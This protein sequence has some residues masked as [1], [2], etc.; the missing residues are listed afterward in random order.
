MV[1]WFRKIS[2]FFMERKSLSDFSNVSCEWL[3]ILINNVNVSSSVHAKVAN[4]AFWDK[5]R[6]LT[7]NCSQSSAWNKPFVKH[8]YKCFHLFILTNWAVNLSEGWNI[9]SQEPTY[10]LGK[11]WKHSQSW[12]LVIFFKAARYKTKNWTYFSFT[13]ILNSKWV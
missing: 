10:C 12:N 5:L 7:H 8:K 9:K 6:L 1:S 11:P 2:V 3:E 4:W 13:C